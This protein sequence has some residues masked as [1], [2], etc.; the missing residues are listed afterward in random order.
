MQDIP[1]QDD[2][3]VPEWE[4]MPFSLPILQPSSEHE[5]PTPWKPSMSALRTLAPRLGRPP[6]S[7]SL[8]TLKRYTIIP[9]YDVP[10]FDIL[11]DKH[12][13]PLSLREF[14]EYLLYV[15]R[16][17]ENLY[18]TL[19]SSDPRLNGS[20]YF[21]LWL[22]QYTDEYND[23]VES[24]AIDLDSRTSSPNYRPSS[25]PKPLP[26]N[27]SLADSFQRAREL[28]FD[29]A[30]QYEINVTDEMIDPVRHLVRPPDHGPAR[31]RKE[32]WEDDS[33]DDEPQAEEALA[34][35]GDMFATMYARPRD[36]DKIKCEVEGLL[37]QSLTRFLQLA[38]TNS[39]RSHD[40][41]AYSVWG[42]Y[43]AAAI[44]A[45][46]SMIVGRKPRALRLIV[47]P[48][49]LVSWSV[50]F[51]SLN[52][53][54]TAIYA[55]GDA[56]QLYPYELYVIRCR[57]NMGEPYAR[58][59]DYKRLGDNMLIARNESVEPIIQPHTVYRP[60]ALGAGGILDKLR[61]FVPRMARRRDG[62]VEQG[63]A[64]EMRTRVGRSER[65]SSWEGAPNTNPTNLAFP[66]PAYI[67]T[68]PH[69]AIQQCPFAQQPYSLAPP[70][71]TSAPL[72]GFS[73]TALRPKAPPMPPNWGEEE[74]RLVRAMDLDLGDP[75]ALGV[76]G[77]MVNIP[78]GL[79]RRVHR[80]IFVRS[81]WMALGVT[82]PI[83]IVLLLIP[84]RS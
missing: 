50:L 3:D 11:D 53:I 74:Q 17:P 18:V 51:A 43:L 40:K 4:R 52:G 69:L 28:F 35:S 8:P 12:A 81:M 36:L 9:E 26:P 34:V 84:V 32:A 68:S 10:L 72:G 13:S 45:S 78:S 38:F 15:E 80:D 31:R 48:M 29:S 44:A 20:R 82:V 56:R 24:Q 27:P 73:I 63:G 58:P 55:F 67:P 16:S 65:G 42:V 21:S 83:V 7:P 39:G 79:V 6:P 54:C 1:L 75:R 71:P 49:L 14:E 66:A 64:Y 77:P 59:V 23:W 25:N 57:A 60:K 61:R 2:L 30:S 41:I 19:S 62:D 37:R 33:N 5:Q 46:V 22:K 47:I 70:T 76:Y